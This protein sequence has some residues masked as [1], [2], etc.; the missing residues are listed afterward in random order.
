MV[1]EFGI[2]EMVEGSEEKDKAKESEKVE[3]PKSG[4]NVPPKS[5]QPSTSKETVEAAPV[6]KTIG[7]HN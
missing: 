4:D 2:M 1:N 7:M 6:V 3:P 5:E